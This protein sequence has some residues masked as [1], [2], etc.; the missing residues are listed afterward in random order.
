MIAIRKQV[1]EE[2]EIKLV[3][4]D[5]KEGRWI[6]LKAKKMIGEGVR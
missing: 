2:A 6:T 4:T 3:A 5:Q 1:I